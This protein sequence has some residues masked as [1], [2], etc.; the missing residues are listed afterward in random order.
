M[1]KEMGDALLISVV[2]LKKKVVG[3]KD[4]YVTDVSKNGTFYTGLYA[5]E[6]KA[7]IPNV[8]ISSKSPACVFLI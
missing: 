1:Q 4:L 7:Y 3:R 8:L 6:F 2:F 5:V